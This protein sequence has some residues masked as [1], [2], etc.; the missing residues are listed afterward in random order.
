MICLGRDNTECAGHGRRNGIQGK[1]K[2]LWGSRSP[3]NHAV[4]QGE[5][6]RQRRRGMKSDVKHAVLQVI[7]NPTP[8]FLGVFEYLFLGTLA[9]VL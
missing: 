3:D 6:A 8:F 7:V 1:M 9:L 2:S 5:P 4:I